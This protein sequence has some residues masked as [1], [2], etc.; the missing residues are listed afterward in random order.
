MSETTNGN[1]E[2][3]PVGEVAKIA[4][5]DSSSSGVLL[6]L[7]VL[8]YLSLAAAIG[9][10]ITTLFLPDYVQLKIGVAVCVSAFIFLFLVN[11]QSET[12]YT[13]RSKQSNL[14]N[15]ALLR[16]IAL[17]RG[18][19]NQL[20]PLVEKALGY[21]QELIDDYKGVRTSA[22]NIYYILQL[23]TVVLSGVTPILVLVDKLEA[24]VSWLKW[25]PVICPAAASI[26]ASVATSFAFQ[27]KWTAAD[28][29]VELLEAEQE[30]FVLGASP[31]Y[32]DYDLTETADRE[33]RLKMA[34]ANFVSKVNTIHL[35]Q[36]GDSPESAQEKKAES[37]ES[38]KQ[39]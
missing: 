15:K 36:I 7:K 33:K 3:N 1:T 22:R 32:Q 30:K 31:A 16:N 27:E 29:A 28:K 10:S 14:S 12:Y 2:Q 23:G 25:L 35:K 19:E 38:G 4:M 18:Q 26:I 21:C 9:F 8:E 34:I 39:T 37:S 20:T 17:S 11:R 24:G 5:E 13:N 6:F